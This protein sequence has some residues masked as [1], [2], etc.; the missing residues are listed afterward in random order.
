MGASKL[1]PTGFISVEHSVVVAEVRCQPAFSHTQ[2]LTFTRR[3]AL[4]LV[5]VDLA[6]G[7]VL[8]LRVEKY[9]PL[10]AAAGNIA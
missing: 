7:K 6:H 5:L 4:H 8:R 1:V 9:Q 10:T 3:V 2:L